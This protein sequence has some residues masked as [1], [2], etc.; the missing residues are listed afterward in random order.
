MQPNAR[1]EQP[2]EAEARNERTLEGVG[3]VPLLDAL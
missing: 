1:H 3:S 2:P